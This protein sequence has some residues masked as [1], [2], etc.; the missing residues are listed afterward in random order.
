M[1]STSTCTTLTP[2]PRPPARLPLPAR[3]RARCAAVFPVGQDG[4]GLGGCV[5]SHVM[6]VRGRGGCPD[7]VFCRGERD[8]DSAGR[9]RYI[10]W[11]SNSASSMYFSSDADSTSG[12]ELYVTHN[13]RRRLDTSS[14]IRPYTC[15]TLTAMPYA[16]ESLSSACTFNV[17]PRMKNRFNTALDVLLV[18]GKRT[19]A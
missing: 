4:Q 14:A 19:Y 16:T 8:D 1:A 2:T 9:T 6:G 7:D 10:S 5:L 18:Q 3:F 15:I 11:H 12:A 17:Y 13:R